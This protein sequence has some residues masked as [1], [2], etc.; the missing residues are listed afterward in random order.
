M[1]E[2]RS[3]G[4]REVTFTLSWVENSGLLEDA[5]RLRAATL[6]DAIADGYG[7]AF[8]IHGTRPDLIP[9]LHAYERGRPEAARNWSLLRDR[10]LRGLG[11]RVVVDESVLL[12]GR[13]APRP[14]RVDAAARRDVPFR[15]S[16][17]AGR[18]RSGSSASS[19]GRSG[20]SSRGSRRRVGIRRRCPRNE[21][22]S[23]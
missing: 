10:V 13:D 8:L 15:R 23:P 9:S 4:E 3:P 11:R 17:R 2:P 16:R 18:P 7:V 12:G 19:G 14:R 22:R 1:L 5:P 6:P 21:R 20:T